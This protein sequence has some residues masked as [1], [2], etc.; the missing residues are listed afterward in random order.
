MLFHQ[1]GTRI[2]TKCIIIHI[3]VFSKVSTSLKIRACCITRLNNV[4]LPTLF[5]VVN[6][7]EQYIVE[8]ESGIWQC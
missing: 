3:N 2:H 5:I 8:P 7:I 6:N 4:V 1:S